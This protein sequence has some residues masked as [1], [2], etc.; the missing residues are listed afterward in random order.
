M[1]ASTDS[2]ME[3]VDV[4]DV[5]GYDV[6]RLYNANNGDADYLRLNYVTANGGSNWG[7]GISNSRVWFEG[8]EAKEND[9][10]GCKV[11]IT[12]PHDVK[13][14]GCNFSENGS[15]GSYAAGLYCSG[16][17]SHPFIGFN[18]ELAWDDPQRFTRFCQNEKYGLCCSNN[19]DPILTGPAISGLGYVKIWDN[20]DDQISAS[21]A[22]CIPDLSGGHNDVYSPNFE[23]LAFDN[24]TGS[25][26][27]VEDNYWGTDDPV[28]NEASLFDGTL[29]YSPWN[30]SR[31]TFDVENSNLYR[32]AR[33]T[34]LSDDPEVIGSSI[35]LLKRVAEDEQAGSHRIQCINYL[36]DACEWSNNDFNELRDYFVDFAAECGDDNLSK[37]ALRQSIWCLVDLGRYEDALTQFASQRRNAENLVDSLWAA[38]DEASVRLIMGEGE[39]GD[40]Y[41][42]DWENQIDSKISELSEMLV[43]AEDEVIKSSSVLQPSRFILYPPYPNPFNSKVS[44][45]FDA[46]KAIRPCVSIFDSNGRLIEVLKDNN[47]VIGRSEFIWDAHGRPSGIYFINLSSD[48]EQ[49]SVKAV[50][51]R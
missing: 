34:Y 7:Y 48:N 12:D 42:P 43:Q 31:R 15:V 1:F 25:S 24:N 37:L 11:Y 4:E 50:L 28:T 8:C 44:V 33:N 3:Y 51:V 38:L 6:I 9:F 10:G 47:I 23:Q 14:L 17:N 49:K 29:D 39:E 26:I 22:S 27:D 5:T 41:N 46:Y 13:I 35:P 19:S 30:I 16:S 45:S 40:G 36:R 18:P 32:L 2:K 20:D 21:N